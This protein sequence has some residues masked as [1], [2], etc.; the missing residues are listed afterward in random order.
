MAV[1]LKQSRRLTYINSIESLIKRERTR[2]ILRVFRRNL[3]DR[4]QKQASAQELNR[5]WLA[6]VV[7]RSI[8]HMS[9]IVKMS[10]KARQ[11]KT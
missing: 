7:R 6:A 11:Q 5:L 4:K 2:K 9:K 10:V 3:T 1:W 8:V